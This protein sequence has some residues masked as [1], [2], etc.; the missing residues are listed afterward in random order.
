MLV[1]RAQPEAPSRL[2]LRV[3][4]QQQQALEAGDLASPV[5]GVRAEALGRELRA[6]RI[7]W[8]RD[9]WDSALQRLEDGRQLAAMRRREDESEEQ[10]EERRRAKAP[11]LEALAVSHDH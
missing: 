9:R 7:G 3:L 4:G 11:L 2:L 5:E 6:M 8:G 1:A 10:L